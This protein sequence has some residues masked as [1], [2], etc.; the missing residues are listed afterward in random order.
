MSHIPYMPPDND[1]VHLSPKQIAALAQ[2][3]NPRKRTITVEEHVAYPRRT[4]YASVN[5]GKGGDD[6]YWQVCRNG[7]LKWM[8]S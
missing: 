6:P 5:E 2:I 1:L 3:P 4:I 7:K 8:R